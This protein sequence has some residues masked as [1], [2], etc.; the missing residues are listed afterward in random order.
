MVLETALGPFGLAF[1]CRTKIIPQSV[2]YTAIVV[3]AHFEVSQ[4]ISKTSAN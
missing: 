1:P 4:D 3:E 2:G